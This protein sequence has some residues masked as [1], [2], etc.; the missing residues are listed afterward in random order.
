MLIRNGEKFRKQGYFLRQKFN[1]GS[2]CGS[3]D[4]FENQ[5]KDPRLSSSPGTVMMKLTSEKSLFVYTKA[6]EQE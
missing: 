2:H 6:K 5:K 4:E 1:R 3:A